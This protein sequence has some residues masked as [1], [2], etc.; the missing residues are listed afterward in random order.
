MVLRR[1][2]RGIDDR[3]CFRAQSFGKSSGGVRVM[4]LCSAVSV[5]GGCYHA[6][7]LVM[8]NLL[9]LTLLAVPIGVW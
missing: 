5:C 1:V 3:L 4:A 6:L 2:K 9:G 7:E 8:L